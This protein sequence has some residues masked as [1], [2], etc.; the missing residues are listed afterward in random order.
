[1][2]S[3]I[4]KRSGHQVDF[5]MQKIFTAVELAFESCGKKCPDTFR[6]ILNQNTNKFKTAGT[7]EKIQ[8]EIE[9]LLLSCGYVKIYKHFA[10]YRA[11][12]AEYRE[13]MKKQDF[14]SIISL[15]INDITTDNGNMNAQSPAG[16]MM[17][18]A[19]ETTKQF[20]KDTLLAP[21]VLAAM[22]ANRIYVHDLDYYPTRSLTCVQTP[23]NK[24][25]NEGMVAG[26]G[27]IRG[28]KH[29]ETAATVA[30]IS[31][32]TSQNEM[33][34]GQSIPAF[35][36]Y[37]APYV[38]LAFIDELKK[39]E[40]TSFRDLSEFYN[41]ELADYEPVGVHYIDLAIKRTVRRVH[42]AM[43]GFIHNA[44]NIHSRGGNQVVFSSIN[45]GTD[46]SAEGRL[47]IR[48]VLKC[49][50]EGVGNGATA[51]FPIHVF[52]CKE[53]VNKNPGDPNYDLYKMSWPVAA[54][55]F[56][57]NYLNLDSTFNK[58]EAW[59]ANDPERYMHEVATMGALDGKEH[60]Y[61]KI[62]DGHPMDISIKDFFEYCKTNELHNARPSQIFYNKAPKPI[63]IGDK[64]IQCKSC[65]SS[66]PGVYAITY[67][68]ED[69]TY[70]GST[71][72]LSRRLA[73]HK[74][75]I[76]LTGK[77]DAGFNPAD[78]DESN[79]KFEVLM[80]TPNYAKEEKRYIEN[81]P[82]INFRGTQSKYYKLVTTAGN[83]L[84]AERPNFKQN[85]KRQQELIDLEHLD[86]K[87]LDRNNQWTKVKHVFKNDRHNTPLMMHIYYV[88]H[89]KEYC[90][91]CTEDH[92]LFTGE[93]FVRADQLKVGDIIY[94]ADGLAMPISRIGWHWKSV[95]SYD[96][97]TASG[98]FIGSDIIMHNCRTRTYENGFGPK[99]SVG[100]GNLSFTSINLPGL[101]IET[102]IETGFYKKTDTGYEINP[103]CTTS[104][105]ER[106]KLF[107][108]KLKANADIVAKQLDD[109]FK[110]QSKALAKQFPLLMSKL[111]V[112]SEGLKQNDT[113]ESVINQGTLAVSFIG[114]AEALIMLTGKHHGED[115]YS[116]SLG[117]ELVEYL[118]T[119][120]KGYTHEYGH[121]YGCFA[122][123]AEGLSGRFT[124][125][126]RAK[127]GIIKNVTDKDYYTNSSHVPVW[128]HC[129]PQHKA[130]IECPYHKFETAGHIFYVE[131]DGDLNKN[132]EYIDA[133]NRMAWKND[134]GYNAINHNQMRCSCCNYEPDE[135]VNFKQ[136]VEGTGVCPKCGGVMSSLSRT[137][138]YLVDI[139]EKQTFGKKAEIA[140]RVAHT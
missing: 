25:L 98:T 1:M 72:S 49:T 42:Q 84:V 18:F 8:D 66:G 116:Q 74:C 35:D 94:R 139:Y 107:R 12:R 2:S 79:Y 127:Y 125:A 71:K 11:Q 27:E 38:R 51:I 129:T 31:L 50:M 65:I 83:K 117:L 122:T 19:S 112:G 33:H 124:I 89:D 88:E 103:D 111:W 57:P 62:G 123:P 24:V 69:L 134:C 64:R 43:E 53:G 37:M 10:T 28:V 17:K 21:D 56:F 22:N 4:R 121:N 120:C 29:I 40:E 104:I 7:V 16:M 114:L 47:I 58:D 52:K 70:I 6:S 60:L 133:I 13:K 113:I 54:R 136:I 130:E 61:I 110:F 115:A 73:E 55:R 41:L 59:D 99:T 26:H 95:D 5:D 14:T 97:G 44:N 138:G 90:L 77:I 20:S 105:S 87:V 36:F 23:L 92:P 39:I 9:N 93:N 140:A 15:E 91:S 30:M 81:L 80:E 96:I 128:Y 32:E 48:E 118:Y 78:Y 126:D 85:L 46:T 75:S 3:K 102:A 82:N 68:P 119:L 108:K 100:R 132:P 101:A 45:Y 131:T 34:G 76:K 106:I 67:L 109:R 63:R 137:T 86:I 135:E